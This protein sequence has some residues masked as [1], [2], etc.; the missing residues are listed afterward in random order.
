MEAGLSDKVV[1]IKGKLQDKLEIPS[2]QERLFLDGRSLEDSKT[3]GEY[4]VQNQAT[5][6]LVRRL[7]RRME[8]NVKLPTRDE[9]LTL[10]VTPSDTVEILKAKVQA[11]EGIPSHLLQLF[12]S[13]R[14]L[15]DGKSLSENGVKKG[16]IVHA[17]FRDITGGS[18][19]VWRLSSFHITIGSSM[20][21]IMHIEACPSD[22]IENVQAKIQD[23]E[24]IP[25]DQQQLVFAGKRL[26]NGRTLSDYNIQKGCTLLLVWKVIFVKTLSGTTI[27][28]AMDVSDTIESIKAKVQEKEGIPLHQQI[29]FFAGKELEN[30]KTLWDYKIKRESTLEL[31]TRQGDGRLIYVRT[32]TD[33]I[34]GLE[35]GPSDTIG[36]VKAMI[37]D[38]E[39]IPSP[40][41][42]L[43][44]A[45]RKL[46]DSQKINIPG[47]TLCLVRLV[48]PCHH[49]MVTYVSCGSGQLIPVEVTPDDTIGTLK[50]RIHEKEVISPSQQRL[51][52][53]GTELENH[54]TVSGCGIQ[55]ES[56]VD[57]VQGTM[58]VFVKTLTRNILTLESDPLDTT[59][60]L[61]VKLHDKLGI[62]SSWQRLTFAGKQLEDEQLLREYRIQRKSTLHLILRLP[63]GMQ[64]Y[65]KTLT[66]KGGMQIFVK[67]LSGSKIPLAMD[68]SDT[69]DS[70]K[71]KVQEKEGILIFQQILFF[72]GEELENDKTLRD[73]RIKRGSTLELVTRQGD[74]RLIYVR[75]PTDH[76]LGLEIGPSD[77]IQSIK[78]MIQ[79]E[80]GIPSHEQRLFHALRKLE[81]SQKINIPGETLC[82]VRLVQPCHHGMVTYVSCGSGKLIPVEVTPNDTIG[83]LKTRI[84]EKEGISPSQQRLFFSGTELE[85]HHT[86]SGCGIQRESVVD[87]VQGT[88]W[89]FVKIITRDVF[90]LE[91]LVVDTLTLESDPSDTTWD[92]KVK[93]HDKLGIPSSW[94]RLTFAGKQLEDVQLL[95]EYCIQRK[96][97]LYLTLRLPGRVQ[98]Y[99]ETL[100]G[101]TI[102]LQ[103]EASDTIEN[104]KAKIQYKEGFPPDQQRLIF[105]GKQLRDGR[106][107]SDYNIRKQSTLYL[108][109]RL[110]GGM[111]I[112]VKTLTGRTITLEAEA[113]DTIENVKAKIQDKEGIPPDQQRLIFAGEQLEDGRTLS[114]YNIQK[115]S[116]LHLVLRVRGGVQIFVKTLTGKAITLEVEASDTIENVKA[117]IQ[118]KEGIPPD[119]QRLIF[120]GEQLEDGRTLS[121]YN[122][123]KQSTLHLVLRVRGGVQIFVKTLTGKTITLEVEAS[124]TIENV[125]AKIQDKEGIPPD[126]QQ[127]IFAGEQ[128]ED[129]RT[130]SD[131]NIQKQST[132]HLVLR[133]RGGMQIFVKTLTGKTI[134]LEVEASDTIENVKAKI[135]DKEGI[136]PDQQR[137]IFAGEQ[138]EDGRT[139]SDYNIQKESTLHLVLRVRGGVQIFVK[140]LTGK[141][142]TLKVEASD[143]IENVKA[144]IQDKEG[145][146]PDQQQILFNNQVLEDRKT[147]GF[148]HI[149]NGSILELKGTERT[150]CALI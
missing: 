102:T 38:I 32:P 124:D 19:E 93:L 75:T 103:V 143:T 23:K 146:P 71:A 111:Q 31:V 28:L 30:D 27:P 138:L 64:I 118:D 21:M 141:T 43:F 69:I 14:E 29:L 76:I 150:W 134:T 55:M 46:E 121:D 115:Q 104:V 97:T 79:D 90:T 117:K 50:T 16:M 114:D 41:Q 1:N 35:I 116:T 7:P 96:S 2:E 45:L 113:S 136:P 78:A 62:P 126:Q 70:V 108:V 94:Q 33:H 67:T 149:Q 119:Q 9:A 85:N 25:L 140:T 60:D 61:K 26:D 89:V 91:F 87:L 106:T 88:R 49:G 53:S 11:K 123:Q 112:F 95:R 83:T 15:E 77:T 82:L 107:L 52:F 40:E 4:N 36:S 66:G 139:L 122:I 92:L 130:L 74:G 73:Y 17:L 101:K 44:H 57:L 125:K 110:R 147:F 68:V 12:L 58:C 63:G 34:L 37:Q 100:T 59:W 51:F 13:D 133:V 48:K 99:V 131:Y 137:L 5:L 81:D 105:A 86:V 47:E 132:L 109:L 72:A 20:G 3:L 144:K 10:E 120:A 129:G 39:G 54:H 24:G 22:I 42:Q 18:S 148:Y 6:D 8:I 84:H 98:I 135:Q 127:L 56:V 145:I 65:V 80:E 142:I 128:L